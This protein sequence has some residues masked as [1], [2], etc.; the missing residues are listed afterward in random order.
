MNFPPFRDIDHPNEDMGALYAN[1]VKE[2]IEKMATIDKRPSCFI[3][4]SLQSCGG[5]VRNQ[6]W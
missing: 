1:D 6:V 3:A 5:K 2:I 4:E